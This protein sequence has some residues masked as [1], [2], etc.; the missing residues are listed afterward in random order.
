MSTSK[1]ITV[2]QCMATIEQLTERL[3][4]CAA[5]A[6]KA[7]SHIVALEEQETK[8]RK[9]LR[10]LQKVAKGEIAIGSTPPAKTNGDAT[11]TNDAP[12]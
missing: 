5:W 4:K 2:A 11:P 9:Q 6:E 12:F 8:T 1:K 7:Q 10:F 3:D